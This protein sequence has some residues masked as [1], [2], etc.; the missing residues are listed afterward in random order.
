MNEPSA[1]IIRSGTSAPE[2]EVSM[3]KK[4]VMG[5]GFTLI[6]VIVVWSVIAFFFPPKDGVF[7]SGEVE[8]EWKGKTF[9][10]QRETDEKDAWTLEAEIRDV[11]LQDTLPDAEYYTSRG[12]MNVLSEN[13]YKG[14]RI[15][16]E[17][18][19]HYITVTIHIENR[20]ENEQ[21]YRF[22]NLFLSNI[23][24]NGSGGGTVEPIDYKIVEGA[25]A[26]RI[27]EG[28]QDFI[29][30]GSE[31]TVQLLYRSSFMAE[32]TLYAPCINLTDEA[33]VQGKK[34]D[35]G[36]EGPLQSCQVSLGLNLHET[37][38]PL[39]YAK[40]VL[41][42]A[43]GNADRSVQEVNGSKYKAETGLTNKEIA[44]LEQNTPLRVDGKQ[45]ASA[46]S[47][48]YDGI[49]K[50]GELN[51]SESYIE[52][53]DIKAET[54]RSLQE[55]PD[56]F[57]NNESLRKMA[58]RY[59]ESGVSPEN[60]SYLKLR[61]T[62]GFHYN[63]FAGLHWNDLESL[64]L[65]DQKEN[66]NFY[67]WGYPDASYIVQSDFADNQAESSYLYLKDGDSATVELIYVLYPDSYDTLYLASFNALL[68]QES[69]ESPLLATQFLKIL[70]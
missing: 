45:I 65:Y 17:Q 14:S 50:N 22:E 34:G 31:V 56:C 30:G 18:L 68:W 35:P 16:Y 13:Y 46:G 70:E 7:G 27:E 32:H 52:F 11:S 58:E 67:A 42:A 69:L 39:N 24:D 54:Y 26:V 12:K 47:T 5:V 57:S 21:V 29:K 28:K 36:Y 3:K 33:G 44:E 55:L 2:M 64:W 15:D 23:Y 1:F 62:I 38:Y 51:R 63:G 49:L 53:R 8:K 48:I 6:G 60:L 20:K 59:A 41:S 25:E 9:Y 4:I 43:A 66:G 19:R 40:T 37:D 10:L 61:L